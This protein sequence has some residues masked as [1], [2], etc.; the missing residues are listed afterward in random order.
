MPGATEKFGLGLQNK[1]GER[2]TEFCQEN[3]LAIANTRDD[4]TLGHH[5]IVNTKIRF[6]IYLQLKIEKL[7]KV[8]KNKTWC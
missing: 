4:S 5:Q 1:A 8:N 7:Y 3:A 2:L 6:I